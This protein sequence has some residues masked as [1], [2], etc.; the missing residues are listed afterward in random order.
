MDSMTKMW[1]SFFAIG[2]MVF[3]ALLITF[4]RTK[5]KGWIRIILSVIAFFLLLLSLLYA[6]ISIV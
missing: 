6:F 5:T 2:L 1:V 3:A 4:A